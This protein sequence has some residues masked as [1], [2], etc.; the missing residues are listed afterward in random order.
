MHANKQRVHS[1]TNMNKHK[2]LKQQIMSYI[3]QDIYKLSIN[4]YIYIYIYIYAFSRR[5]YP[6]R[7]TL[8]SSYS[9]TFYQ[10]YIIT[11]HILIFF[12]NND[13]NS[14]QKQI[15]YYFKMMVIPHETYTILLKM[16]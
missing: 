3:K 1:A 6:K 4:Y 11:K 8:H 5:F 9:F 16:V 15:C 7:L 10:L 12:E 14:K 2:K 13:S